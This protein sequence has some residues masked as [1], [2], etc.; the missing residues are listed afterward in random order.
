[1]PTF[2]VCSVIESCG[3]CW[4]LCSPSGWSSTRGAR[5]SPLVRSALSGFSLRAVQS[6]FSTFV[7]CLVYV[8]NMLRVSYGNTKELGSFCTLNL[9]ERRAE[10]TAVERARLKRG[11]NRSSRCTLAE[12]APQNSPVG[13]TVTQRRALQLARRPLKRKAKRREF[14]LKREPPSRWTEDTAQGAAEVSGTPS[15]RIRGN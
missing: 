4:L 7:L 10:I 15:R 8:V 14:I 5:P 3:V 11:A 9:D 6:K 12:L 1:L 2:L 13:V